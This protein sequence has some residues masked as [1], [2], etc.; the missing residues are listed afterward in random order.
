MC[1]EGK[2][3]GDTMARWVFPICNELGNGSIPFGQQFQ[4]IISV[5]FDVLRTNGRLFEFDMTTLSPN[6]CS[7]PFISRCAITRDLPFRNQLERLQV[8]SGPVNQPGR[9]L[10]SA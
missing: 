3:A 7:F 1:R 4:C 10:L 9:S 8:E 2:S 5:V 6:Q